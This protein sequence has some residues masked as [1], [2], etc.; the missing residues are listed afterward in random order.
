MSFP[1]AARTLTLLS[2]SGLPIRGVTI[3]PPILVWPAK[4]SGD[5]LDYSIDLTEWMRDAGDAISQTVSPT[6]SIT[7]N[8]T[9]GDMVAGPPLVNG[10][11]VTF[12]MSL[13]VPGTIYEVAVT[14]TT[15]SNRSFTNVVALQVFTPPTGSAP[16]P[17]LIGGQTITVGG[18]TVTIG[19]DP[20]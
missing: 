19:G 6:V 10:Q 8:S 16:G 7:P 14:V 1:S 2:P 4:G 5:V 12:A 11:L 15:A 18:Q 20:A 17:I 3:A 13:G 9:A